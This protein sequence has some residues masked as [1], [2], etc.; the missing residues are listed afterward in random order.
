M[1]NSSLNC[2]LV[3]YILIKSL[4]YNGFLLPYLCVFTTYFRYK[5]NNNNINIIFPKYRFCIILLHWK[6]METV[7]Y[8]ICSSLGKEKS[9][10]GIVVF[11]NAFLKSPE[12]FR[13]AKYLPSAFKII[14]V[15]SLRCSAKIYL[16]LFADYLA[17]IRIRFVHVR[18]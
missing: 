10:Q 4:K 16:T 3:N 13:V 12:C 17:R 8:Y 14:F 9:I 18:M 11:G 2:R 1:W 5:Q 7:P 15:V 6:V